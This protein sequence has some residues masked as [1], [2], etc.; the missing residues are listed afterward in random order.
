[1]KYICL[2]LLVLFAMVS[3]F[4]FAPSI[5]VQMAQHDTDRDTLR[6][7]TVILESGVL[8]ELFDAGYIVSSLPTIINTDSNDSLKETINLAREG[9]M[10]YVVYID[11]H[12][13]AYGFSGDETITVT[14]IESLE[15][16]VVSTKDMSILGT[17]KFDDIYKHEG[18]NDLA[19][20]KRLSSD[21]GVEIKRIFEK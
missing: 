18:E 16:N 9:Y 15:W 6:E 11:A 10:S 5:V 4:S 20:M 7:S 8:D 21:L 1:M 12:Y 14:D 3:A 2:K 13:I 17:G 19:A